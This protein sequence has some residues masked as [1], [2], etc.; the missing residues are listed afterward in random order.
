[1]LRKSHNRWKYHPVNSFLLF[2]HLSKAK[3]GLSALRG[4]HLFK[5]ITK[6]KKLLLL[7]SV[8]A[9]LVS[10]PAMAAGEGR[11]EGRAAI[12]FG[13][14]TSDFIAGVAA[15]YDF[16]LGE[17]AFAGPEVSY[18]TNFDGADLLNVGGRIG[19]KVGEKG[20]L[21]AGVGY[22]LGDVEE[23]NVS[24]GYQHSFGDKVYGKVEYRRYFNAGSDLNAAG[25]GI[26]IKF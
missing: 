1:M 21:Y 10:A 25:V 16:D 7:A 24:V 19:A 5:G 26:G 2:L 8:A 15:G 11:V 18:D 20:K 22:D 9:S 3:N 12:G 14:G 6:M 4:L 17:T 23:L 13:G